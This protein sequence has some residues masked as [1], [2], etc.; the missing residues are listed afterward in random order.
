MKLHELLASPRCVRGTSG[1]D[2]DALRTVV[3]GLPERSPLK[4]AV[5]RCGSAATVRHGAVGR[6]TGILDL[7]PEA[8]PP[9][10]AL[11]LPSMPATPRAPS[12]GEGGRDA[13]A[14]STP[15]RP[16][17]PASHEVTWIAWG[18]EPPAVGLFLAPALAS[19][20]DALRTAARNDDPD[21]VLDSPGFRETEIVTDVRVA[22][23]LTPLSYRVYRDTP[24]PEVQNLMLRRGIA[25]VP[26]VGEDLE[27]LGL[28]TAGD[29]LRRVV[30]EVDAAERGSV[31]AR[32][33]M[34]RSVFC[35][36][37]EESLAEAGR[38]LAARGVAQLPVVREGEIVG[39]LERA[40]VMRAFFAPSTEPSK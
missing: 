2:F 25:A 30:S 17:A 32:A 5:A 1:G 26:V 19:L 40:T 7:G 31:A 18:L 35:V 34:T 8:G 27:V 37:G 3:R 24:V 36:S 22:H 28:I 39:F 15:P 29:L 38:A 12:T 14:P 4:Q 20:V 9:G 13:A 10:L 23:A 11:G 21:A 6:R 33:V 16:P